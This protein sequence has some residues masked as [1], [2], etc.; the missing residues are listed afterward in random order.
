[1]ALWFSFKPGEHSKSP[2]ARAGLCHARAMIAAINSAQFRNMLV[3]QMM[4][5]GALCTNI[6]A[7]VET[8]MA[9]S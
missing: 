5:A 2:L 7:M 8:F 3:F 4:V 6:H 1:M 9:M